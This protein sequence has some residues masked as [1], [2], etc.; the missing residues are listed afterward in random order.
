MNKP[1]EHFAYPNGDYG[2]REIEYVKKCGYKSART[3]DCGWNS[4]NTD[5]FKLKVTGVQDDA[6]I[7]KLC[8]QISGFFPILRYFVKKIL[9]QYE[10]LF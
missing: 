5:P 3:I 9:P 7:N 10:D 1:I 8:A 4:I 6:S 2:E